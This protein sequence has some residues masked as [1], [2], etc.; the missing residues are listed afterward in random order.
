[1]K[2]FCTLFDSYYIHKGIALY[3]SMEKVCNDFTLYVMAFDEACYNKLKSFT[4]PNM[5]VEYE[6]GNF[7]SDEIKAVKAER[8]RNEYCWTCGSNTTY[9][10]LTKYKLENITYIDADMMFFSS[11]DVVFEELKPYSVGLSPHF[12]DTSLYGN[13]CVQFCYFKNDDKGHCALTWWK[14]NCLAWCY[15]RYEDGKF[16]DQRYLDMM[17]VMFDGVHS[18]ENRGVGVAKWNMRDYKFLDN[19]K[20]D[21]EG[22]VYDVC[23]YHF[24]AVSVD[25]NDRNIYISS[26]KDVIPNGV[27]ENMFKPYGE[28]MKIV[29]EKYLDKPVRNVVITN[30]GMMRQIIQSLKNVFRGNKLVQFIF[31]NYIKGH[32]GYNKKQL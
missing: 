4:F 9:Y 1:M 21:Y 27:L 13:F 30:P 31:F 23:F 17:P 5:V 12:A 19:H 22:T 32:S 7:L 14:N 29:Y 26:K 10:F 16:G 2:N 18:I 8:K 3:L 20:I 6:G 25:Y 15:D 28:L 24:H 11:P